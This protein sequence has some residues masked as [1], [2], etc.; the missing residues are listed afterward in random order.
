MSLYSTL[1]RPLLFRLDA[2]KAHHLTVEAC[3]VAGAVPGVPQLARACLE[4]NAPELE[5]EVAGLR[6]ANPIGLAAGWDKSGRAVRMLDALGLGFAEIG[7]VSA[8]TSAG[9]PKP[10]LFRLPEDRAIL[11]N[12]GLPNDGAEAVARRLAAHRPRRPLGVNIVKTNDGPAAPPCGEHEI[13][14]DYVRSVALLHPHAG[15]L[16]LNLSCPNAEGGKDFFAAPGSIT[17]LLECLRPLNVSCPVFL[18]VAPNPDPAVIERIVAEAEPFP[19]VRGFIFNLPSGR[20]GT[21]RFNT[22]RHSFAHQ[23]GAVAG[24]PVA[25]L[26]NTCI[27]ELHQRMPPGRFAIIGAGGVF[28]AADAYEKIRL[29]ASLVQLY[30]ALVYEGPGV[31]RRIQR[32]LVER[33]KRDGF[34][35]VREAIGTAAAR[36]L[37]SSPP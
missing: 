2:E 35:S 17:R 33:L 32:G 16:A 21:L 10:R 23:P 12:Y 11:V 4:F 28:T 13:L 7:S 6:F 18:K 1:V 37:Q 25:T 5:I 20:P 27:R 24:P 9:N 36:G 14:A 3:R 15:Y 8:R 29:G 30:T 34:A 26:I 22:P 31:I 19:L